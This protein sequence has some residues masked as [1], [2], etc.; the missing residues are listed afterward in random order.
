MLSIA[1]LNCTPTFP[2]SEKCPSRLARTGLA[3]LKVLASGRLHA[4]ASLPSGC[5][6]PQVARQPEACNFLARRQILHA[7]ILI[8]LH[9][10]AA[11]AGPTIEI[12]SDEPGIGRHPANKQDLLLVHYVGRIKETGQVFD[13][14]LGG[15]AYR[16]GGPGVLRPV[17][18]QIGGGPVPGFCA[19]L[20]QGSLPAKKNVILKLDFTE[21]ALCYTELG[22]SRDVLAPYAF[23][24]AGSTL[25]YDV[26]LLRLS[27]RGPDELTQGIDRCGQGGAA[28]Q[29][30]KCGQIEIAEF[31]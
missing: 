14:T 24:P 13:S 27:S 31:V 26:Q 19:G 2:R 25:E 1:K 21:K 12:T 5:K 29:V 28:Q 23:V 11:S 4:R 22:F 16:D 15:L 17:A 3:N 30:E 8:G 6:E 20:R 18:L 10:Q 7:T 9:A